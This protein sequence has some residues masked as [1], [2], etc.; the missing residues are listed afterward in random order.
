MASRQLL[1]ELSGIVVFEHKP[2]EVNHGG[3]TRFHQGAFP[4]AQGYDCGLEELAVTAVQHF[5]QLLRA[6][7]PLPGEASAPGRDP[8]VAGIFFDQ[9]CVTPRLSAPGFLTWLAQDVAPAAEAY[10]LLRINA[11]RQEN[12]KNIPGLNVWVAF[13]SVALLSDITRDFFEKDISQ[14]RASAKQARL[15]LGRIWVWALRGVESNAEL[16]RWRQEK[17]GC[18]E[19]DTEVLRLLNASF[20]AWAGAC[21]EVA[22]GRLLDGLNPFRVSARAHET[23]L[24][25]FK[26]FFETSRW[27][28]CPRVAQSL[29][30]A[31]ASETLWSH[32]AESRRLLQWMRRERDFREQLLRENQCEQL[33]DWFRHNLGVHAEAEILG[34]L[35]SERFLEELLGNAAARRRFF[36]HLK[37]RH[38]EIM[39]AARQAVREA[40]KHLRRAHRQWWGRLSRRELTAAVQLAMK[41]WTGFLA[42]QQDA[43][44]CGH[45][46]V[47]TCKVTH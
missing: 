18:A 5:A 45:S 7:V 13:A 33:R 25:F 44:I 6:S 30:T 1:A 47:R 11:L 37:I 27:F 29:A 22:S 10:R 39:P 40:Q 3:Q 38:R 2:S 31:Q 12:E 32:P 15:T 42:E 26:T 36:K 9:L 16:L 34:A 28:E 19:P 21:E 23:W 35:G 24:E 46:T 8:V 17:F 20:L 4:P 41:R 14:D 43:L